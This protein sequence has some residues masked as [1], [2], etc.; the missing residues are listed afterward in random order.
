MA[1]LFKRGLADWPRL[2]SAALRG[3]RLTPTL[4]LTKKDSPAATEG[5]L[6]IAH[7]DGREIRRFSAPKGLGFSEV[8]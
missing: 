2:N 1:E 7:A 3:A 8:E 5:L 6:V 4:A